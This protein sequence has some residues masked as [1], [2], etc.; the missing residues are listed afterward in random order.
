MVLAQCFQDE[1]KWTRIVLA[2]SWGQILQEFMADPKSI[3]LSLK[4]GMS[5]FMSWWNSKFIKAAIIAF[6]HMMLRVPCFCSLKWTWECFSCSFYHILRY[7]TQALS[8]ISFSLGGGGRPRSPKDSFA[9]FI[10]E[11]HKKPHVLLFSKC[12]EDVKNKKVNKEKSVFET[13]VTFFSCAFAS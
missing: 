12:Q 1:K 7:I 13:A 10:L 4:I 3:F 11:I 5:K 2:F 6:T 9:Q 8:C